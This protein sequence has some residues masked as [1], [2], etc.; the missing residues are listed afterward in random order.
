MKQEQELR[1]FAF[2]SPATLA[3][4]RC[5]LLLLRRSPF[6]LKAEWGC[7]R[8]DLIRPWWWERRWEGRERLQ[9]FALFKMEV[10]VSKNDFR[11]R[12][13]RIFIFSPSVSMPRRTSPNARARAGGHLATALAAASLPSFDEDDDEDFVPT[14]DAPTSD[15]DSSPSSDD[16]SDDDGEG[17]DDNASVRASEAGSLSRRRRR[18]P[19]VSLQQGHQGRRQ[20]RPAESDGNFASWLAGTRRRERENERGMRDKHRLFSGGDA[21]SDPHPLTCLS[22]FPPLLPT[23]QQNRRRLRR[24][25]GPGRGARPRVPAHPRRG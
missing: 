15:D 10:S 1:L 25:R 24:A 6:S 19:S 18:R 12:R 2:A 5:W 16:E 20:A 3:S 23:N 11:S 9:R 7:S 17:D 14:S 8:E 4:C 21:D 13:P 22:N